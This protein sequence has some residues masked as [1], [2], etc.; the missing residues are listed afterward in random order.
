M[1]FN[2][3]TDDRLRPYVRRPPHL[4]GET[5]PSAPVVGANG[6]PEHEV[7]ELLKSSMLYGR[8]HVLPVV[9][10]TG[11]NASG[12]TWELLEYLTKCEEAIAAFERATGLILPRP[13]PRLPLAAGP[14]PHHHLPGFTVDAAP[15]QDLGAALVGR[16]LLYW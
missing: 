8:P 1:V 2:E 5:G 7:A 11:R 16:Q 9:R 13:A 14:L 4:G 10:W 3:F 15:P 12:D 6:A